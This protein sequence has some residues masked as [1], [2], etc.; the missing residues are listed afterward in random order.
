MARRIKIEFRWK[1]L[2]ALE[3]DDELKS[4]TCGWSFNFD[5]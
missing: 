2:M 4:L 5:S 3:D 1:L